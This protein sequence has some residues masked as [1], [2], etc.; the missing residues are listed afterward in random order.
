MRR[1]VASDYPRTLFKLF[2]Q[3]SP[4][5]SQFLRGER[6]SVCRDVVYLFNGLTL[7]AYLNYTPRLRYTHEDQIHYSRTRYV[8]RAPSRTNSL[9]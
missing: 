3:S 7:L 4:R 1:R 2:K 8:A 6:K 5:D 9:Y